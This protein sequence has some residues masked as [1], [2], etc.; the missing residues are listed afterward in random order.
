MGPFSYEKLNGFPNKFHSYLSPNLDG[1]NPGIDET[2]PKTYTTGVAVTLSCV[3]NFGNG[4]TGPN[5]VTWTGTG[6]SSLSSSEY[7]IDKVSAV[8][9]VN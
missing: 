2:S 6:I 3:L 7:A 4:G 8:F 5:D 9:S 1:L